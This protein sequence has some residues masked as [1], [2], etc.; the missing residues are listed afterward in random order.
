MTTRAAHSALVVFAL[1]TG[2]CTGDL[3]P[4]SIGTLP[5][6]PGQDGARVRED[7]A[8]AG[9]GHAPKPDLGQAEQI[10]V[11]DK[12]PPTVPSGLVISVIS[13][14]QVNLSWNQSGDTGGSGLA[15]YKVYRNS[16]LVKQ[17]AAAAVSMSDNGLTSPT[18]YSYAV[19][20]LDTAGNESAKSSTA[21]AS[22]PACSSNLPEPGAGMRWQMTFNDEFDGSAIDKTKWNGGYANLQWCNNGECSQDYAGLS[23]S[24]GILSLQSNMVEPSY[25]SKNHR[26]AMHTG[27]LT[28]GTARFSQR[29]GYFEWRA[30]Y[31]TNLNG[32]GN[33][34][35]PALWALPVGKSSF[36]GGCT[37]GNEEVDVLEIILGRTNLNVNI[38]TV[39]D[40]CTNQFSYRVVPGPDLTKDFHLYG[41]YWR[42]DGSPHGSMQFY[43]DGIPQKSPYVVDSRAKLWDNGIYL[44]NQ[45]IPCNPNPWGGGSLCTNKTS[46]NNPLQVDWVRA[47]KAIPITSPG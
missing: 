40:Y 33:G 27:G 17:V 45:L 13:C 9:D 20:A 31:P 30:K 12:I 15:G 14:S 32:E 10:S 1:L 36:P 43:F 2:S 22:T 41:L 39:H 3:I 19:S 18:T 37:E 28:A 42:D 21:L 25:S 4:G 8:S 7:G 35:W 44:I 47:Y 38:P 29:F 46:N 16:A 6:L 11:A 5:W 26:A 23:V 24:N 34:L